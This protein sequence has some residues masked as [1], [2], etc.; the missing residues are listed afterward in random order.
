M[1]WRAGCRCARREAARRRELERRRRARVGVGELAAQP[2][3][4]PC[5]ELYEE[6]DRLP[7]PFRAAVVLCD[8]EGHSYEQAAGILHCPVGTLQSRLGRGRERLRRRLERQG[9]APAIILSGSGAGPAAAA[10]TAALS[11]QLVTSIARTAIDTIARRG[12]T[13]ATHALAGAEIRRQIMIRV[14]TGLTAVM[15]TGLIAATT[16]GLAL[17]G[18]NDDHGKAQRP[19]EAT[20]KADVEPIHVRVVDDEAQSRRPLRSK[21]TPGASQSIRSRPMRRAAE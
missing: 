12:I 6:L 19:V 1:V 2:P 9:F 18:R 10:A 20:Q 8:L 5:P 7:E 3:A 21:F 16:I 13:G 15:L 17:A 14:L 4:E 11:R